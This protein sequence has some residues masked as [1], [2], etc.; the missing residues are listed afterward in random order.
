MQIQE[1]K[2]LDT[3]EARCDQQYSSIISSISSII[4]YIVALDLAVAL[5]VDAKAR[6]VR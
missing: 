5:D 1:Q 2:K 4:S 3:P 6:L